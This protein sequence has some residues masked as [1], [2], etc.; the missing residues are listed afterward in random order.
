LSDLFQIRQLFYETITN[1]NTKDYSQKEIEVWSSSSNNI[2][3]WEQK[4][5]T[6]L[7]V[8]AELNNEVVSFSSLKEN[9][10]IDHLFVSHL[11]QRKRISTQLI[12]YVEGIAKRNNT[13]NLKLDVSVTAL[14]FFIK[15]D[16]KVLKRN[17]IS[18]K[19]E[20]LINFDICKHFE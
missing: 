9:T 18:L 14:P 3:R 7:F 10:Y 17:K 5:K 8:V 6:N 19:G 20:V 4:F 16:Y 1:V 15:R 13:L 2:E 12:D 11:H